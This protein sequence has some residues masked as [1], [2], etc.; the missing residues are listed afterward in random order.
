MR[1][2]STTWMIGLLTLVC[3]RHRDLA[4]DKPA[5]RWS[6]EERLAVRFAP[7]TAAARLAAMEARSGRRVMA[8]APTAESKA[9]DVVDGQ[10]APHLFLQ[11]E[12]F[13]N[14]VDIILRPGQPS[15]SAFAQHSIDELMVRAAARSLPADLRDI[16]VRE[17]AVFTDLSVRHRAEATAV[18]AERGHG[19]DAEVVKRVRA[20]QRRAAREQC[21][22]IHEAMAGME[23]ALGPDHWPAFVEF[24]Y[25]EVAPG[26]A[27]I[28]QSSDGSAEEEMRAYQG[29]C[30]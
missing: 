20:L 8:I 12:V 6:D 23:R 22:A 2:R 15:P 13:Q 19:N 1:P 26:M 29:G 17:A 3:I 4:A 16:L 5:W 30:R 18:L 7:G 10:V 11:Q 28:L 21:R 14:L 9:L 27:V 24:L 25:S